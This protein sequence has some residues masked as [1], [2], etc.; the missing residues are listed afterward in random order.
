MEDLLGVEDRDRSNLLKYSVYE[1]Y[2]K[3]LK[4]LYQAKFSKNMVRLWRAVTFVLGNGFQKFQVR[5]NAQTELFKI[6]IK[7]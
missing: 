1:R 6:A 2:E 3:G 4:E 7:N 5:W